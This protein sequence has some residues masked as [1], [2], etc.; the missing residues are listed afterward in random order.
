MT[1]P[2][3]I[4]WPHAPLHELSSQGTYIVTFERTARPAQVKT[5]Y[6]FKID[7]LRVVDDYAVGPGFES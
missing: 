5:I 3:T 2:Q 4:S 1:A 7:K 6:G